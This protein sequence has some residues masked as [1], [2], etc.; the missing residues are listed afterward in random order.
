MK[1]T[2]TS[3]STTPTAA[4]SDHVFALA[5]LLGFRFAPR[6]P[7]LAERRLYAFG[8]ASRWTALAPFIAQSG[9]DSGVRLCLFFSLYQPSGDGQAHDSARDLVLG[10]LWGKRLDHL[11]P[12][13]RQTVAQQ[14]EDCRRNAGHHRMRVVGGRVTMGHGGPI[15]LPERLGNRVAP[16]SVTG[17]AGQLPSADAGTAWAAAWKPILEWVPSQ[18][19]FLVDAPQRHSQ[20]LPFVGRTLP[21]VSR[22]STGPVTRACKGCAAVSDGTPTAPHQARNSGA[23]RAPPPGP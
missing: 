23:R 14:L 12:A 6:I 3:L 4:V 11:I 13:S 5:A 19:G 22:S 21:S 10:M 2:W 16:Q 7:N 8:P 18:S 9:S 15:T 20:T 17:R 1:R